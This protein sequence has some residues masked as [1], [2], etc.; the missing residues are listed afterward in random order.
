MG[1][2]CSLAA[3]FHENQNSDQ[4]GYSCAGRGVE[5]STALQAGPAQ[6][7][8]TCAESKTCLLSLN[9]HCR[10]DRLVLGTGGSSLWVGDAHNTCGSHREVRRLLL[11]ARQ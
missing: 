1:V 2:G 7:N 6:D 5:C 10:K 11:D 9:A 8:A 3:E 4:E